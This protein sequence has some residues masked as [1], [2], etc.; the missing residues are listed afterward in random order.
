VASHTSRR[1]N[2]D[3]WDA[4]AFHYIDVVMQMSSAQYIA[5]VPARPMKPRKGYIREIAAIFA[6]Y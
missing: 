3:E 5:T 2:D 6:T 4:L 1:H